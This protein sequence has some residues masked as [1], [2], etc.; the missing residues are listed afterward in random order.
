MTNRSYFL[1]LNSILASLL[2]ELYYYLIYSFIFTE[3]K[4]NEQINAIKKFILN[5]VT[6]ITFLLW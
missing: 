5:A 2:F 4:T 1:I 3:I 6:T